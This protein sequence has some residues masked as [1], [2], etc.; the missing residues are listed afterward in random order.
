MG[1]TINPYDWCTANNIINRSQ[2]T[3]VWNVEDLK[4]SHK[5]PEMID[6]IIAS[7]D[8]EYGKIGKM[9]VRRGKY[10]NI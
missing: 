8:E 10:M 6:K 7:L 9:T 4:L 2:C 5:D 3:I 1:F